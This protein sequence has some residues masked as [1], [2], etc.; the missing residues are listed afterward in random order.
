MV[1]AVPRLYLKSRRSASCQGLAARGA[2]TVSSRTPPLSSSRG[3]AHSERYRAAHGGAPVG[4]RASPPVRHR[5]QRAHIGAASPRLQLIA[6]CLSRLLTHTETGR[7]MTR[8]RT[9]CT[10]ALKNPALVICGSANFDIASNFSKQ[11]A[12]GSA[13]LRRTKPNLED[14]AC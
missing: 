13:T 14:P 7:D 3:R 5:C 4:P 11:N 6:N 1:V 12:D 9:V 8:W 2:L 10:R